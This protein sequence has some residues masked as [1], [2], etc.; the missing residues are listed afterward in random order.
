MSFYESLAGTAVNL[1][2]QFGTQTVLIRTT[3]EEFDPVT[4]RVTPGTTEQLKTNGVLTSF[5]KTTET[6]LGGNIVAGDMLLVL[7]AE[8][9]PLSTDKLLVNGE[10]WTIVRILPVNPAGTPISYKVQVR[11]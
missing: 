1:L 4:G 11:K 8:V 5:T 6:A 10:P 3:G 7:S 2:Q 9:E